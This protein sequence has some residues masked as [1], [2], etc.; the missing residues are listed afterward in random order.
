MTAAAVMQPT[1]LPWLGYLDLMDQVDTFV[2]LDTVA[3]DYR[4]WQHRNRIPGPDGEPTWLSVPVSKATRRS[5]IDDVK[6]AVGA[7]FPDR[8][9]NVLA[10]RYREVAVPGLL[11][12][13][14]ARIA[15]AA[16]GRLV[17]LTVP[18]VAWL[19]DRFA[20]TTPLVLASELPGDGRRSGLLASLAEAV[21]A[22]R[23][24]SPPGSLD[25]LAEDHTAFDERSIEVLVHRYDH[26]H[27]DQGSGPFQSHCSALDLALRHPEAAAAILRAGRRPPLSLADA[28]A[29]VG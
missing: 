18:L 10:E 12:E 9:V 11:H 5:A 7:E 29:V 25:Y 1:Y 26:P 15:G 4:S 22:D 24:V 20:I 16:D 19:A 23:Y 14:T 17:D 2:L 21:G 27:Y 13:V 6:I 28:L 3:F 8:H